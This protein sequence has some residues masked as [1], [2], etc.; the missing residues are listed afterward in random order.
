MVLFPVPECQLSQEVLVKKK[1]KISLIEARQSNL[2]C[3]LLI[4]QTE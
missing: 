2:K 1:K 3:G 4:I